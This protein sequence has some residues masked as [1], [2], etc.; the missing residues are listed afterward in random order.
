MLYAFFWVIPRRLKFICRR[1]G[2][3]FLFHL[4]KQVGVH[5]P[6]CLWRWNRV[7]RNVGISTSDFAKL[8]RR[9]HT[10]YLFFLFPYVVFLSLSM[11][12]SSLRLISKDKRKTHICL[13]NFEINMAWKDGSAFSNV[14]PKALE[15]AK[16]YCPILG[17]NR[18]RIIRFYTPWFSHCTDYGIPSTVPLLCLT[19][20]RLSMACCFNRTR[21]NMPDP[22]CI[23][24]FELNVG[25]SE[26]LHRIL[27]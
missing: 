4:H 1:F 25:I 3:L 24:R 10:T 11:I 8:P 20:H 16:V 17:I 7:F 13:P 9:K 19:W 15:K 6:T 26:D 27:A 22:W 23:Q 2:T 12:Y 14:C 18:T 5:T 21:F